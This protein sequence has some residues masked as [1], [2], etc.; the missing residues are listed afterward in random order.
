MS[1]I[2]P[3]LIN[4]NARALMARG[5]IASLFGMFVMACS[6]CGGGGDGSPPSAEAA[7]QR[8]AKAVLIEAYGDSTTVGYTVTNGVSEINSQNQ[9]AV[10]Q[11]LLTARFGAAVTV[12]NQGVGST[13]ASQLLNGTDGVHL[14]WAQQ[15]AQSKADIVTIEYGLNDAYDYIVPADGIEQES[16]Q[17]FGEILSELVRIAQSAGK[18][19]ILIEPTPSCHPVRLD[20]LQYYV[21]Q[22]DAVAQQMKVP[23]V[24][25]YWPIASMPNWQS[26]LSDCTHP[27]TQLYAINAQATFDV[28]A[29]L[30]ANH[31]N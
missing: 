28:I 3:K 15:M 6:G 9:I 29:P 26:L 30:I 8:P 25:H 1:G 12:S 10:L 19:V 17:R 18:Q 4:H 5:I 16:P 2:I 11:Q 20:R 24:S 13:E 21:M 31:I 22:V 14:P 23:L 27:T 7:I